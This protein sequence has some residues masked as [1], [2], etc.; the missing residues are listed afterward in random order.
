MKVFLDADCDVI[1][2]NNTDDFE[3]FC[4]L[5]FMTSEDFVLN[6]FQE[7]NYALNW[8]ATIG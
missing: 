1:E 7:D 2:T 5:P 3:E 4:Q 8:I 6:Y